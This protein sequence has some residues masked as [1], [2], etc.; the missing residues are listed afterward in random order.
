MVMVFIQLII[1]SR[2]NTAMARQILKDK[3]EEKEYILKAIDRCDKCNA[4]AYVMVKGSTGDLMFCGH[5]YD[6]IMNDPDGYIKM[7]SFMLEVVDERDRLNENK[8]KGESY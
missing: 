5:H 4:Q 6:K 8:S 7:M 2:Y 3:E 1:E